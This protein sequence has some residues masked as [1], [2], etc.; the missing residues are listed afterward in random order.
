MHVALV[1]PWEKQGKRSVRDHSWIRSVITWGPWWG[2]PKGV[3]GQSCS[4]LAAR[5]PE[6]K[7]SRINST[8]QRHPPTSYFFSAPPLEG[9]IQQWIHHQLIHWWNQLFNQITLKSST[10]C[11]PSHQHVG[12]LLSKDRGPRHSSHS[13]YTKRLPFDQRQARFWLCSLRPLWPWPGLPHL[14]LFL[15]LEMAVLTGGRVER[16]HTAPS[17]PIMRG[18]WPGL[19]QL[20][21]RISSR[22]K[23]LSLSKWQV[24]TKIFYIWF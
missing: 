15:H 6:R 3:V 7:G 21:N 10:S 16:V 2:Q 24:N 18:W 23:S 14:G 13:S 9:S 8:H 5:K 22:V 11:W 20:V 4:P 12:C 19:G 17:T 1:H